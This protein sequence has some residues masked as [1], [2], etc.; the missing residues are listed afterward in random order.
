[1]NIKIVTTWRKEDIRIKFPLAIIKLDAYYL[2]KSKIQKL[3]SGL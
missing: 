2:Y 1:M 3:K